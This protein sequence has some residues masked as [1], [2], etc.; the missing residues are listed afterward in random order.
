M[1]PVMSG[2]PTVDDLKRSAS[3]RCGLTDFGAPHHEAALEA[4]AA[5]LAH[6]G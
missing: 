2:S 5:D 3:D 6:P 1:L 4:W